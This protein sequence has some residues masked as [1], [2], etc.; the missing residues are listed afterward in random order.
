MSG[1]H[2]LDGFLNAFIFSHF[3]L[4]QIATAPL[5]MSLLSG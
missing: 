3:E 1:D 2:P 4:A 5:D